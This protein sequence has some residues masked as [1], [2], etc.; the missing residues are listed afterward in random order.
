MSLE[1]NT[2]TFQPTA[3]TPACAVSLATT[4]GSGTVTLPVPPNVADPSVVP[5]QY[6]VWNNGSAW[7]FVAFGNSSVTAA[8]PTSTAAGSYPVAP[9]A[10]GEPAIVSVPPGSTRPTTMAAITSSSST[11]LYVAPCN[12]KN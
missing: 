2:K 10:G 1:Q 5:Q 7:A 11:T 6:A 12:G 4:T 3:A 8:V 9:S